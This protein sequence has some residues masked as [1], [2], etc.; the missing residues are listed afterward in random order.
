MADRH[1]LERV[2]TSSDDMGLVGAAEIFVRR[3]L[4]VAA[5]A[6]VAGL[7]T[8]VLTVVAVPHV[9]KSTAAL[10]VSPPAFSSELSPKALSLQAY[11]ALLESSS[12]IAEAQARLKERGVITNGQPLR[13]GKELEARIFVS[14]KSEETT[15]A[16][17]VL[18]IARG[19]TPQ[20]AAEIA[21]TWA[22]V[23]LRS[24]R[25]LADAATSPTVEF[26]D[27]QYNDAV[28]V[29]AALE[30]KRLDAATSLSRSCDESADRWDRE[31]A[32]SKA[33]AAAVLGGYRAE[34]SRLLEEY[35]STHSQQT[36]RAQINALRQSLADLQGNQARVGAERAR[37][38]LRLEAAR[39][40]LAATPMLLEVRKAITD[41]ALWQSTLSAQDPAATSA[42]AGRSLVSQEI[43]PVY[44]ELAATA[45]RLEIEVAALDPRADQLTR[46][47]E[48]GTEALREREIAL[49][50]DDSGL[51]ALR[52][53]REAGLTALLARQATE[54]AVQGRERAR[55]LAALD[56]ERSNALAAVDRKIETHKALLASLSQVQSQAALAR[57][58]T[59]ITDV[60]LVL[61]AIAPDAPEPRGILMR[62]AI[63]TALGALIGLLLA[64]AIEA[65]ARTARAEGA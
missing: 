50:A 13:R 29:M 52:E 33:D 39:A 22:D 40:A 24:L 65:R 58:Q 38:Q 19:D 30:A 60:R 34:T 49:A 42:A 48:E 8:L 28:T 59:N 27:R 11:Q 64:L 61:P 32:R 51:A 9:W 10:V 21:N 57:A 17:L 35:E 25:E 18:A 63:G 62:S 2:G 5:T 55:D 14:R 46:L 6:V 16:P 41:D 47:I 23:F 7:V 15:L 53:G 20:Q 31:M 37:A 3:W 43:N 26:V 4:V 12:M 44:S 36:R 56:G 54:A 45:A 1:E